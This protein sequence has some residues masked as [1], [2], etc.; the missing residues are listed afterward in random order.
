MKNRFTFETTGLLVRNRRQKSD[1]VCLNNIWKYLTHFIFSDRY[2]AKFSVSFHRFRSW[3]ISIYHQRWRNFFWKFFLQLLF[4]RE[5]FRR[6]WNID[7]VFC[8]FHYIIS[9]LM[10]LFLNVRKR[11][12]VVN[13]NCHTSPG[14]GSIGS[15]GPTTGIHGNQ[16][17]PYTLKWINGVKT[18]ECNVCT[19]TFGQ[20]GTLNRH[21]RT[22]TGEKPYKCKICKKRFTQMTGLKNHLR[23]HTGE[24]PFSC[25]V[26]G[27][28]FTKFSNLKE[29]LR[30]HTGEKPFSCDICK[31][32]FGRNSHLKLHKQKQHTIE[33]PYKCR[34]CQKKYVSAS[35]LRKH[36]KTSN[37]EPHSIEECSPTDSNG[38]DVEGN[39]LVVKLS[40]KF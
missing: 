23:I 29:H 24:R 1:S 12:P 7:E 34:G 11:I 5:Q 33:R 16:S 35:E 3:N 30:V 17:L 26:C 19:K 20:M 14:S 15:G 22:H 40:Q 2:V 25:Q 6:G 4:G 21:A 13:G 28:S 36:W 37:C 27:K 10:Y 8:V 31:K 39:N 38:S 18:F 9:F 32:R